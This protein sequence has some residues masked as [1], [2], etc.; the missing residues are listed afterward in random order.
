M[1]LKSQ[2][3]YQ[4]GKIVAQDLI[5]NDNGQAAIL[6]FDQNTEL[7]AHKAPGDAMVQVVEGSIDFVIGGEKRHL[8]TGE[9]LTMSVGTVHEVYAPEKAKVILTIVK[10][11]CCDSADKSEDK[12]EGLLPD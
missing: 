5:K 8:Q 7:T 10:N 11:C 9:F 1:E 4:S 6:A 2:I 3:G 12:P